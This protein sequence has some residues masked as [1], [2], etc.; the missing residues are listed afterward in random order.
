MTDRPRKLSPICTLVVWG[1]HDLTLGEAVVWYHDWA[2]D[3]GGPD[4]AYISHKS[5]EARLG[6]KLTAATISKVRQRLKSLGLHQSLTRQDARNVGWVSI[7]PPQC[8]PHTYRDVPVMATTLDQYLRGLA[9]WRERGRDGPSGWDAT[10]QQD[11]LHGPSRRTPETTSEA[12]ALV[13]GQ[14]GSL[15]DSVGETQ[16]PSSVREKGIGSHEPETTEGRRRAMSDQP[17]DDDERAG[18]EA[19]LRGLPPERAAMLR[20]VAGL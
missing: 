11:G 20:R 15:L 1:A 13:G 16:L 19:M 7:L 5:M 17:L 10:V 8:Q 12:A 4:G 18:F 9:E 14:G 3:Q 6:G 2:L